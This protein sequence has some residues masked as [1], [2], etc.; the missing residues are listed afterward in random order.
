MVFKWDFF[1]PSISELFLRTKI[2]WQ[3]EKLY[4]NIHWW[5]LINEIVIWEAKEIK[6]KVGIML[7]FIT[8]FK[9]HSEIVVLKYQ[10]S[11]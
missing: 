1:V 4:F 9:L 11:S 8:R 3:D 10:V 2:L 7:C 6:Y 5:L